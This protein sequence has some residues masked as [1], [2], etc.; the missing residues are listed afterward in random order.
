MAPTSRLQR[1][2]VTFA[3][4]TG[5][6][7]AAATPALA[8]DRPG[9]VY[10]V[11]G[12]AAAHQ[13]GPSG[14]ESGTYVTAPGGTT[15]GWLI[16]GGVVVSRNIGVEAELSS[17]GVMAAREPSRYGMTFNEERR[18]RF[19]SVGLRISVPVSDAVR[20]EPVVGMVIT[21]PQAWFQTE[22]SSFTSPPVVRT[23]PRQQHRLDRSIGPVVGCDL[24]IGRG[25]VALV[26]SFRM[27]DS[28]VSGGYYGDS[29]FHSEIEGIYPGGYPKWTVRGGLALRVGF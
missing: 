13:S 19:L 26:P 27:A 16:G 21:F 6:A 9:S 22:Y 3:L 17:T 8:Q 23:D 2:C 4:A 25:R 15:L 28:G 29:S 11:G 20:I 7:A 12:V 10:V 1:L 24:R 14:E 18:D 5:G